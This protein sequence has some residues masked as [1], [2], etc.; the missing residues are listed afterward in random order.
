MYEA[1][2]E[3]NPG[4]LASNALITDSGSGLSYNVTTVGNNEG[5]Y[6]MEHLILMLEL[7][8]R[9]IGKRKC[10]TAVYDKNIT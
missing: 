2:G 9:I 4:Q 7:N 10:F 1:N 5:Y 8:M 6:R 3:A